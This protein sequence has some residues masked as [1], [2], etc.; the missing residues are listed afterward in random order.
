MDLL[1]RTLADKVEMVLDLHPVS[2]TLLPP[3]TQAVSIF[4]RIQ[5]ENKTIFTSKKYKVEPSSNYNQRVKVS[6]SQ[7]DAM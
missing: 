1:K 4:I 2:I 7:E 3:P 5:R 6:F